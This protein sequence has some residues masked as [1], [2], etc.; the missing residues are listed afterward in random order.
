M[1]GETVEDV[2]R[3]MDGIAS[4][5]N[6]LDTAMSCLVRATIARWLEVL[7]PALSV[8][9]AFGPQPA[10]RPAAFPSETFPL[11]SSLPQSE[12]RDLSVTAYLTVDHERSGKIEITYS[13]VQDEHNLQ[14]LIS[15]MG[16]LGERISLAIGEAGYLDL[17]RGVVA[18]RERHG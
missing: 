12:L 3:E 6:S 2:L 5:P 13:S 11:R 18:R 14:A 7:R 8:Q 9:A 16:A 10:P 15:L 4:S 1:A 17:L